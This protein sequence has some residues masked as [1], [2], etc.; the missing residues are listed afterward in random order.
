MQTG[1]LLPAGISFHAAGDSGRAGDD[2]CT[3]APIA[4]GRRSSRAPVGTY[5][6]VALVALLTGYILGLLGGQPAGGSRAGWPPPN[7]RAFSP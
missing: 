3:V 5:V 7:P 6:L 1:G 2:P 4:S